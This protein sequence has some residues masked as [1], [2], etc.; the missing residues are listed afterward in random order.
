[1][2]W[3]ARI[4]IKIISQLN[5]TAFDSVSIVTGLQI[6][7]ERHQAYRIW[8]KARYKQ[9][10]LISATQSMGLRFLSWVFPT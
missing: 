2:V 7:S 3:I 1:M 6:A 9:N 8:T 10:Q 5:S 4:D